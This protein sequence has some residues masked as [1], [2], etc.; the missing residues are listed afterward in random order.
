MDWLLVRGVVQ[1]D[2]TCGGLKKFC[3]LAAACCTL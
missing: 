3:I 2:A 1:G